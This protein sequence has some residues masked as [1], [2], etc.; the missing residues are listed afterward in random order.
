MRR[1]GAGP[2]HQCCT[3]LQRVPEAIPI[4]KGTYSVLDSYVNTEQDTC[5]QTSSAPLS[6]SQ[7]W[8]RCIY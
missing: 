7:L 6:V 8:E 4:A 2:V 1:A 5:A 3:A